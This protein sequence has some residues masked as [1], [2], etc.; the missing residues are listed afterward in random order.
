MAGGVAIEDC[1][2]AG[3]TAT[4]T[5]GLAGARGGIGR[6]AESPSEVGRAGAAVL[7]EA[8]GGADPPA[9]DM[10][11]PAVSGTDWAAE[12][13]SGGGT[14]PGRPAFPAGVGLAGVVLAGL[15]GA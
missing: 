2:G 10:P 5:G 6:P 12:G 4:W 11:E 14:V 3:D 8:D 1:T 13:E 15:D 7:A 9:D